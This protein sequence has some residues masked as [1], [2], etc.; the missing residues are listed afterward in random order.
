[1]K[2]ELQS[3]ILE[4]MKL[5]IVGNYDFSSNEID[6]MLSEAQDVFQKAINERGGTIPVSEYN[7]IFV[8]IVNILK[9]WD[10]KKENF[11][12]FIYRHLLSKNTPEEAKEITG[13]PYHLIDLML[14]DL[15]DS[16]RVIV[17]DSFT[18]Q[19]IYSTLSFHGLV[20][21][22]SLTSLFEICWKIYSEDFDFCLPDD[23]SYEEIAR[24]LKKRVE[25]SDRDSDDKGLKIGT[26]YYS[27]RLGLKAFIA[28]QNEAFKDFIERI[29]GGIN[30]LFNDKALSLKGYL[31]HLILNWWD[32]KQAQSPV[33][34][35]PRMNAHT[36]ITSPGRISPKYLFDLEDHTAYLVI[37]PFRLENDN[38]DEVVARIYNHGNQILE[39]ALY[40][41]GSGLF[42]RSL[43]TRISLE[44][45]GCGD[46]SGLELVIWDG[47][48][49]IYES[50][51]SLFRD[52]ILFDDKAE[53][54][55]S[56]CP[57]GNYLLYSPNLR[58]LNIRPDNIKKAF[59]G[60]CMFN[61][62]A[63]EGDAI[64]SCN[65][66]VF[67]SSNDRGN[68]KPLFFAK[69]LSGIEFVRKGEKYDVV[70]GNVYIDVNKNADVK[71]FGIRMAEEKPEPVK[72]TS[73]SIKEKDGFGRF[74]ITKPKDIEKP[75]RLV[76]FRY[77]DNK[78]ELAKNFIAFYK[79]SLSFDKPF[80][81]GKGGQGTV[82]FDSQTTH[83]QM[84]F[85]L[86]A[87]EVTYPFKEGT[88]SFQIPYLK[89]KIDK[90]DWH[91]SECWNGWFYKEISNSCKLY[92]SCPNNE[93]PIE[94]GLGNSI[95]GMAD[96]D[97]MLNLGE[98]LYH[99][100][101]THPSCSEIPLS[102]CIGKNTFPIGFVYLKEQFRSEP[103]LIKSEEKKL[104]WSPHSF[105]GPID[106]KFQIVLERELGE[107]H[108]I[109]ADLT[110]RVFD[111]SEMPDDW[112]KVKVVLK[113]RGF[114]GRILLLKEYSSLFMIGDPDSLKFKGKAIRL[115]RVMPFERN[116]SVDIKF[117]FID[118]ITFLGREDKNPVYIGYL[119]EKDACGNKQYLDSLDGKA[120]NPIRI[121]M[122]GAYKCYIGYGM[123][124][125]DNGSYEYDDE[126]AM[127]QN[128]S[129]SVTKGPGDLYI[130]YYIFQTMKEEK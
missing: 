18:R 48:E 105:V 71:N 126:F 26:S 118:R 94:I 61:V 91:T 16:H 9:A 25:K 53:I 101:D 123:Y 77:T 36:V 82:K 60:A 31:S 110:N 55:T 109:D 124:K 38:D 3:K 85:P 52:F 56:T 23:F 24:R 103:I 17:F 106:A 81:Y 116:A 83:F 45:I 63:N 13:K 87:K 47:S 75:Q 76:L 54:T 37:P 99:Y 120:I 84:V 4:A 39:K 112:Y 102:C 121:E 70:T 73:S 66:V 35:K 50:K 42:L 114:L 32:E 43:E 44:D 127:A 5:S 22:T 14:Q 20:P 80:Y 108:T 97:G 1:M 64:Q 33:S 79:A 15:K 130:D 58:L 113:E 129:L 111:L 93:Y 19:D 10:P 41:K 57:I 72:L 88:L 89:W 6:D 128:G 125:E 86:T 34:R 100:K 119:Y 21:Q 117:Y 51:E 11:L 95:C 98:I 59:F 12:P 65:R 40:T 68:G 90:G 78:I 74:I 2:T 92:F 107:P 27:L 67:F 115:V 46:I 122:F 49:K 7:L 30:E 8:T 96:K 104:Y 69:K 62:S 29:I 28:E